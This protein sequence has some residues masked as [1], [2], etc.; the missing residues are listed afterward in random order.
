MLNTKLVT[1]VLGISIFLN[2][3][4]QPGFALRTEE[5][6]E[7]N[8]NSGNGVISVSGTLQTAKPNQIVTLTVLH[9]DKKTADIAFE[10]ADKVIA[11]ARSVRTEADGS[12]LFEFVI[13]SKSGVYQFAVGSPDTDFPLKKDYLYSNPEDTVNALA[14]VNAALVSGDTAEKL[15]ALDAVLREWCTQESTAFTNVV[16]P[17]PYGTA[18][19][20]CELI[21]AVYDVH[22]SFTEESFIDAYHTQTINQV[23]QDRID[24]AYA[25]YSTFLNLENQI[26]Y[27][28]YEGLD[29]LNAAAVLSSLFGR[30]FK[31]VEEIR[32]HFNDLVVCY[33][34]REMSSFVSSGVYGLLLKAKNDLGWAL[35][36]DKYTGQSAIN[37]TLAGK[38]RTRQEIL[39]IANAGITEESTGGKGTSAPLGSSGTSYGNANLNFSIVENGE[40]N[41]QSTNQTVQG[42]FADL[43][44]VEWAREYIERL[45]DEGIINGKGEGRFAPN[46]YITRAEF[47]TLVVKSFDIETERASCD[48]K[49][50]LINDWYYSFVAAGVSSGI[51]NGTETG[52]FSPQ[53][54]I[55]R[56]DMAALLYRAMTSRGNVITVGSIEFADED[57]I[58][59]Y[60]KDAVRALAKAGVINGV[61][62]N[63]FDPLS[64]TTRAQAAAVIYRIINI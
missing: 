44:G 34:L 48:F 24:T 42:R 37:S 47:I 14:A 29:T 40:V 41:G 43:G 31:N 35:N 12:F 20:Q 1:L 49:D 52:T 17:P 46:D 36:T 63:N 57:Y 16:Y 62:D 26:M 6:F 61:G 19:R 5:D 64:E 54:N 7:I 39:D 30:S 21:K 2:G 51:V 60:A 10:G 3:I 22:G 13:S 15:I 56:Q 55:T 32:S 50:V 18:V 11:F 38:L 45:A 27:S 8:Y 33:Q 28:G 9:P 23:T 58:S 59:D 25:Q 53:S 4:A